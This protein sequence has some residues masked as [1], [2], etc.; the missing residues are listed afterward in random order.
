MGFSWTIAFEGGEMYCYDDASSLE[1]MQRFQ[2]NPISLVSLNLY[3]SGDF[4]NYNHIQ[5]PKC[6]GG[7]FMS[8]TTYT[9]GGQQMYLRGK[10]ILDHTF[11]N[12]Q[13]NTTFGSATEVM[14]TGGSGGGHATVLIA[15]YVK[16]LMPTS[17]HKYGA[18]PMSGWYATHVDK[19][20]KVFE[21][22]QMQNVV[23]PG[24]AAALSSEQHKCLQP[25]NS[26]KYSETH[27][28]VVQMLDSQS[29]AGA[30]ADND[31]MSAYSKDAWTDC[32]N[33]KSPH[34]EKQEALALENYLEDLV[35]SIQ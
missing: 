30:Y 15:D 11:E 19:T 32:L 9:V 6:D 24:C 20:E 8:D 27:M 23:A 13:G 2:E 10:R 25:E 7:I 35:G 18:V 17:V 26:Y 22:H 31:T 16:T 33:T 14:L 21:I 12:L 1:M 3:E 29:L 4:A 5:L 34:C 28:F